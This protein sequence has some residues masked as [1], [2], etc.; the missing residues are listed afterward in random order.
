ME[1]GGDPGGAAGAAIAD[2]GGHAPGAAAARAAARSAPRLPALQP[3]N[4]DQRDPDDGH[5]QN[6]DFHFVFPHSASQL[7][8]E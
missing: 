1:A 2:G 4:R 6:Y 3:G 8:S 5:K 7:A